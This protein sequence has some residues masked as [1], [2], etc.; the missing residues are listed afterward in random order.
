MTNAP[1]VNIQTVM[2]VFSVYSKANEMYIV[3]I[4]CFDYESFRRLQMQRLMISVGIYQEWIFSLQRFRDFVQ[5]FQSST[6]KLL[7]YSL[8]FKV[9]MSSKQL[10]RMIRLPFLENPNLSLRQSDKLE[11]K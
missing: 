11:L 1:V 3:M 7:I 6:F 10:P 5:T 2:K 8:N 9:D 4:L